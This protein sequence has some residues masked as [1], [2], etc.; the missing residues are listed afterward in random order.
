[1]ETIQGRSVFHLLLLTHSQNH[2]DTLRLTKKYLSNDHTKA[3]LSPKKRGIKKLSRVR[4][5]KKITTMQFLSF[6]QYW[7]KKEKKEKKKTRKEAT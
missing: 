6:P 7:P 2:E 3:K 1:M 4:R 5:I